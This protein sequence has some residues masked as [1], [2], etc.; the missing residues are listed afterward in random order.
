MKN[1]QLTFN[2]VFTPLTL[3][4]LEECG[5]RLTDWSEQNGVITQSLWLQ[6]KQSPFCVQF[7]E[8]LEEQ[9][10]RS[11]SLK[12]SDSPLEPGFG[13]LPPHLSIPSPEKDSPVFTLK[14]FIIEDRKD[15]RQKI[16][17]WKLPAEIY[18]SEPAEGHLSFQLSYR[19]VFPYWALLIEVD[20]WEKFPRPTSLTEVTWHNRAGLWLHLETTSWDFVFFP[21][22]KGSSPEFAA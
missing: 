3:R 14:G 12:E 7:K 16:R 4:L 9:D 19:K 8:V 13:E 6:T 20:D 15:T 21:K 2:Y 18:W 10:L 1:C 11:L 22:Q 17:D 5:L